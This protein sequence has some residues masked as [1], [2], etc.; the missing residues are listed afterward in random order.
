MLGEIHSARAL[1]AG[2]APHVG[3]RVRLRT[4][5]MSTRAGSSPRKE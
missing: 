3:G 2:L 4:S 1:V 5:E